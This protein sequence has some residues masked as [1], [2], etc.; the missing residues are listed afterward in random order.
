[1]TN[2]ERLRLFFALWPDDR[3]RGELVAVVNRLRSS[4]SAKWVNTDKLHMT[5][6][7][8]GDV[9]ADRLTALESVADLLDGPAFELTLDRIELWRK[10][11]IVCL[12]SSTPPEALNILAAG[13]AKNLR[14]AGFELETRPFRAHLTLARKA[15]HLSANSELA[16][17]LHWSVASFCLVQSRIDRQ[18]SHYEILRDWPLPASSRTMP[19]GVSM[20]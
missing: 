3:V 8:L 15:R 20:K 19:D 9:E 5:L 13:L 17:P 18:G 11:G 16:A 14:A 2:A 12:G 4:V 10:P 7:F 1:M 6:A